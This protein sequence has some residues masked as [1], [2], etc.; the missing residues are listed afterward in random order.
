MEKEIKLGKCEREQEK[1]SNFEL[2]NTSAAFRKRLLVSESYQYK[3]DLENYF[4]IVF[5]FF[6]Y[7]IIINFLFFFNINNFSVHIRIITCF[8]QRSR[9]GMD[10]DY[11]STRAFSRCSSSKVTP[12]EF[13]QAIDAFLISEDQSTIVCS[14]YSH[15]LAVISLVKERHTAT[16]KDPNSLLLL[17]SV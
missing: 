4:F 8:Q 1:L 7:K 17:Y 10:F 5:K 15:Y 9:N 11:S 3:N 13:T 12:F 14:F 2:S 16:L 6:C